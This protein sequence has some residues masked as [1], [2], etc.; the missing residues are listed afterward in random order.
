MELEELKNTWAEL[1]NRLKENKLMNKTI[2]MEMAQ[3]KA[4]KIISRFIYGER[5]AI[6]VLILLLPFILFAF[7]RYGSKRIMWDMLMIYSAVICAIY[8][9]WSMYKLSKLTKID[10]SKAISDNIR[11]TNLYNLFAKWEIMVANVFLVP[12][13]VILQILTY[14]EA[15]ASIYLWV[16][17]ICSFVIVILIVYWSYKEYNKNMASVLKS[18]NEI[19]A[20][21]EEES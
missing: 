13:L 19:K 18:M 16:F 14:A 11:Y 2:I 3:S 4:D 15:R 20:L 8:P 21:E 5:I 6:I 9:I 17:L 10:F 7:H 12:S 1:D